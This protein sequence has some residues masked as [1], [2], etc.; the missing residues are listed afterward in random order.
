MSTKGQ[1]WLIE[2]SF[3]CII[4]FTALLL[5]YRVF[6]AM[7]MEQ[8]YGLD[9][10][11]FEA[12]VI[13]ES[14]DTLGIPSNWSENDVKRIGIIQD[15]RN[16]SDEKVKI[17]QNLSE[18]RYQFSKNILGIGSDYII[19]FLNSSDNPISINGVN[20]IGRSDIGIIGGTEHTNLS[21]IKINN[22]VEIRRILLFD[23]KPVKVVINAW[24]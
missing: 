11:Y 3:A 19:Y 10:V 7:K 14:I 16:I 24:N 17:L 1:M 21:K 9:K 6:P 13:A 8:E 4:F 5:F 20:I 18:E 15:G 23:R 22:L 12:K 2:F